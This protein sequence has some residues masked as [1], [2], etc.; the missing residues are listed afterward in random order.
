LEVLSIVGA[1][2]ETLYFTG[3]IDDAAAVAMINRFPDIGIRLEIIQI[4]L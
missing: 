1:G 3:N 2:I 4:E